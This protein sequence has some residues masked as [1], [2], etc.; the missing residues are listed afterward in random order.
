MPIIIVNARSGGGP[1]PLFLF[2]P[3]PGSN[4]SVA[5]W[6]I[7]W[8]RVQREMQSSVQMVEVAESEDLGWRSEGSLW[9]WT[10]LRKL[11]VV[12]HAWGAVGLR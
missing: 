3:G 7:Q 2:Y 6:L 12:H 9:V 8:L 10:V 5:R 4:D 11:S 1:T